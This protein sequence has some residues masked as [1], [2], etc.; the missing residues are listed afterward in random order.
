[1]AN[2][3]FI[4]ALVALALANPAS[5]EPKRFAKVGD[6]LY[7]DSNVPFP[8]DTS[9]RIGGVDNNELFYYL[10]HN[11]D[12]RTVVL[13]SDGGSVQVGRAMAETISKFGVDTV[14]VG[15]CLSACTDAFMGGKNRGLAKGSAL[16]FH[17]SYVEVPD[18]DKSSK[19]IVSEAF[20]LGVDAALSNVKF[21]VQR[22]VDIRFVLK[23]L[24]HEPVDMWQPSRAELTAAGVLT[25]P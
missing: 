14:V 18:F 1:M 22:G 10:E 16:G 9:D 17:R 8:N 13:N 19:A 15:R 20:D 7:F 6:R 5:A 21:M 3:G 11:P 25:A 12:I 2:R 23:A 24:S 4:I